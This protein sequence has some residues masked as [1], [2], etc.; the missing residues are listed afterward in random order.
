MRTRS[1]VRVSALVRPGRHASP[2]PAGPAHPL[3]KP[4]KVQQ[5]C[6]LTVGQ[7][8]LFCRPSRL[9]RIRRSNSLGRHVAVWRFF[10]PA[11]SRL[12]S[13]SRKMRIAVG[14]K[15]HLTE[16]N[17]TGTVVE[18]RYGVYFVRIDGDR[19]QGTAP[20]PAERHELKV[21]E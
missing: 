14:D 5:A 20:L 2:R 12:T 7:Q 19:W 4:D 9:R 10:L 3:N 17:L 6:A 13:P 8:R 11:D 15:V 1:R 16:L 18:I 21:V